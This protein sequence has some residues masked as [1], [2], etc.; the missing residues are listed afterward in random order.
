MDLIILEKLGKG[1]YGS[2]YKVRDKNNN[3]IFAL[4]I[5]QLD[6]LKYIELDILSRLKSPYL[7]R[8]FGTPIIDTLE[9]KGFSMNAVNKSL[10]N[11]NLKEYSYGNLKR[12]IVS[13]IYGITCMH[14]KGF[15]HMD[16]A[17][18][19]IM[20]GYDSSN[21]IIGFIGDFGF[22]VK[23]DNAYKGIECSKYVKNKGIPYESLKMLE[24][25]KTKFKYSD[26]TDMWS[27]GMCI[28]EM[29][30]TKIP[31]FKSIENHLEYVENINDTFIEERVKLYNDNKMSK[32]EEMYLKELL[33]NML[34]KKPSKRISSRDIEK[35]NFMKTELIDKTCILEKP[36]ELLTLP[37]ISKSTYD[38]LKFINQFFKINAKLYNIRMYFLALQLF[39]RL[40]AR[41]EPEIEKS[42]LDHICKSCIDSSLNYYGKKETDFYVAQRLQGE[43]GYNPMY[44]EAKY[45]DDLVILDDLIMTN[46][47]YIITSLNTINMKELYGYF[48]EKYKYNTT[49]KANVSLEE[50]FT[51]ELPET[52]SSYKTDKLTINDYIDLSSSVEGTSYFESQKKMENIFREI[53]VDNIKENV[54]K[55]NNVKILDIVE[56]IKKN[57]KNSKKY[58]KLKDKKFVEKFL[59]LEKN[60]SYGI[61][62]KDIEINTEFKFV[63]GI[64]ENKTSLIFVDKSSKTVTHYYSDKSDFI[65][66]YYKKLGYK[67]VLDFD[68]GSGYCCKIM[69]SCV[70]FNIF[71]NNYNNVLDFK[72]K[73]LEPKT[74]EV[75][76]IYLL[77]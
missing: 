74:L 70:I 10:N 59:N 13:T 58:P 8:S 48:K 12:I 62:G 22:S 23:C 67:Y 31:S 46:K 47:E 45:I 49:R 42:T 38:G 64:V 75:M 6:K 33:V 21:N 60:F 1:S 15:I 77:C 66:D 41:S 25:K 57:P 73:C 76:F 30:G 34:E 17:L 71:Y 37:Y 52:K 4:K 19:N 16:L 26:K 50:F 14:N 5:V 44:Y 40:M 36:A 56:S 68:Y 11:I 24:K 32:K 7:I 18:R 54:K 55:E 3:K 51:L 39:L 9:G 65:K 27:L 61:I 28:L 35:L 69:E 43:V 2:V 29:I 20:H 63:V 53:I 72:L